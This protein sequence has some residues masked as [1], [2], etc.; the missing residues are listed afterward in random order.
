M[1]LKP[2]YEKP[3]DSA[4]EVLDRGLIPFGHGYYKIVLQSS[5]DPLYQQLG[6]KYLEITDPIA[7]EK[8]LIEGVLGK[9]THVLLGFLHPHEK[10]YG[11]LYTSKEIL[12]GALSYSVNIL[13]KKWEYADAYSHHLQLLYQ[14]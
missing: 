1:L 7:Y 5:S 11:K 3:I 4:Q 2:K 10:K 13:N 8:L 14:V 12:E 6:K 9:N